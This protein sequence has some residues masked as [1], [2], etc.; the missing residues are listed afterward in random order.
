MT[1]VTGGRRGTNVV[2]KDGADAPMD[3]F[4][5]AVVGYG[6]VGAVLAILLGQAG[7]RVV[8]LE[9]HAAPYPLPRAVHFDDETNRILQACGIAEQVSAI[10]EPAEIYEFQGLQ[11]QPI[12]RFGRAGNGLSGWPV[13]SMFAQPELEAVLY[14]RVAELPNVEVRRG[15]TVSGFVQNAAGVTVAVTD[16]PAVHARYLVGSDGANSTIRAQLDLPMTDR[17]FFYDWLIVD[18]VLDAPRA[19]DPINVQICDPARPT[20]LVS[21]GPGRRRWEFMALPGE[22]AAELDDEAMAWQLLEPY[23][24]HPGNARLERHAVY[25]FQARWVNEWRR[26][27]ALLAGDAAHQTPP[28]AGQGM[29]AGL[30]DSVS[31]AWKL[32]LVLRGES[33]EALL[34]T[35]GEERTPN[36]QAVIE[37]AIGM[38]QMICVSDRA[39][40][41]ARDAGM[42][43]FFDGTATDIPPMP[44]V[45]TG[46]VAVGSTGAGQLFLQGFVAAGGGERARL[47]DVV[48]AGWQLVTLAEPAALSIPPDD[49]AWFERIGGT[50]V[51]FAPGVGFEDADG[52][53]ATWFE[54]HGV[55]AALQRPDFRLYGTAAAAGDTGALLAGLRQALGASA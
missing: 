11:R 40:A 17:A 19:Y 54:K 50:V 22:T 37:L 9:R 23:D 43:S 31:L 18:V 16:G 36:M 52:S 7:H 46:V 28:F 35:Y 5:V 27:R 12:A 4:D 15:A 47:D 42:A 49:Q 21:G 26:G 51:S 24:V 33:P 10:V 3:R 2:D 14:D 13:S 41:E 38:G 25:R 53:Y 34:D 8:V 55:A 30:R 39:E 45:E 44:G 20:T 48:G 29:C 32:D 1:K 6:P